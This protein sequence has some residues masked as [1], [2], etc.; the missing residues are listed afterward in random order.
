MTKKSSVRRTATVRALHLL[1]DI[2]QGSHAV[3][4]QVSVGIKTNEL[5]Q[6][7]TL[8]DHIVKLKDTVVPP[9]ALHTQKRQAKYLHEHEAHYI[10]TVKGNQVKPLEELE[11][12][13]GKMFP[14]ETA[15]LKLGM[16][17]ELSAPPSASP[18]VPESAS[19]TRP[20]SCR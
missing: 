6:F 16:G 2:D 7:M 18:S 5:T 17:V 14:R 1:S 11:Q 4:G 10:F 13:H 8:L 20:R 3:L 12:P 9:Y 15:L 19:R